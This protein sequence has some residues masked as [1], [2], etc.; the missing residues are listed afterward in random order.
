LPE[1]RAL[2]C[3]QSGAGANCGDGYSFPHFHISTSGFRAARLSSALARRD[4]AAEPR[5]DRRDEIGCAQ[6]AGNRLRASQRSISR[7]IRLAY[8]EIGE[9]RRTV[10]QRLH[11]DRVIVAR[12]EM[13]PAK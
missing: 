8:D 9:T 5:G 2:S 4:G 11:A 6:R 1:R 10:Q 12:R 7:L 3:V 13:R